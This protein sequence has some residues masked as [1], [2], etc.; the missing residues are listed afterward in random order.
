MMAGEMS[1]R[2]DQEYPI[3]HNAMDVAS[4]T[5]QNP[6]PMNISCLAMRTARCTRRRR[7]RRVECNRSSNGDDEEIDL[8]KFIGSASFPRGI[9]NL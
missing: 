7:S 3:K 5:K 1:S 6:V 9:R 4:R 2:M 8:G